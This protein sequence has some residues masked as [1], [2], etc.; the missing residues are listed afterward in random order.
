MCKPTKRDTDTG[1]VTHRNV[2][3]SISLNST[4]LPD[5]RKIQD[6]IELFHI[7]IKHSITIILNKK[8]STE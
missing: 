8:T 6:E 7:F 3:E 1:G 2:V 5:C 4:T